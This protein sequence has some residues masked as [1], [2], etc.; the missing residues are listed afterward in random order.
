VCVGVGGGRQLSGG[1]SPP[2]VARPAAVA[3]R[4][5]YGVALTRSRRPTVARS[6]AGRAGAGGGAGSLFSPEAQKEPPL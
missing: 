6:P 2:L 3:G 1:R 5:L 4:V